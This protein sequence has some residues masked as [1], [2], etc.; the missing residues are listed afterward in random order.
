[1][2]TLYEQI[3]RARRGEVFYTKLPARNVTSAAGRVGR[4]VETKQCIATEKPYVGVLDHLIRVKVI[5]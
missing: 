3:K 5:T 4:K 2:I 1:M